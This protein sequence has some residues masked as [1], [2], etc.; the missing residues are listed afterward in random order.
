LNVTPHVAQNT[1][2]RA[3]A[4]DGAHADSPVCDQPSR[5][6]KLRREPFGLGQDHRRASPGPCCVEP[7]LGFKF[8]LT[9]AAYDLIRLPKLIGCRSLSS[10][11]QS[12]ADA[13]T[14]R[15]PQESP[16]RATLRPRREFQ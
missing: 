7:K 12:Y 6:R 16:G 4:I 14:E 8:T 3:S 1:S 2:N 11:P 10:E 9:M 13:S 5:K 15:Q